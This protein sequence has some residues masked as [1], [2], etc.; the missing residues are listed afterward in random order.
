MNSIN[1]D[2]T[3]LHYTTLILLFNR[4]WKIIEQEIGEKQNEIT[5]H[6]DAAVCTDFTL[7]Q[8]QRAKFEHIL[9][10]ISN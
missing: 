7:E 9:C 4:T 2:C 1:E 10:N 3:V 6:R 8:Q 5:P